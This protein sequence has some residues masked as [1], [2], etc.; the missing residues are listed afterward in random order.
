MGTTRSHDGRR[1][2]VT[3]QKILDH[4]DHLRGPRRKGID[5]PFEA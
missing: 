1:G 3:H 5:T 4:F 2:A